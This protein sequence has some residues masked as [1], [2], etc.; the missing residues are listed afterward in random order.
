M[1]FNKKQ[2][3]GCL[4]RTWF[5]GDGGKQ[6]P[7]RIG[8]STDNGQTFQTVAINGNFIGSV[9]DLT[10]WVKQ[11]N[12]FL[13][14]FEAEN[15]AP[16]TPVVIDQIEIVIVTGESVRPVL[17]DLPKALGLLLL[18]GILFYCVLQKNISKTQLIAPV[19]LCFI[20][21]LAAYL[22]WNELLRV[23]GTILDDDA[24][25]YLQYAKK[26]AL[27]SSTGFYS[28]Q[29]GL[30]EP[31]FIFVVKVFFF[32][33]GDSDTHLRFVS[34]TFS[35][36][37]IILTYKMGS[38]WFNELV[39]LSAALILAIHPYLIELSARGLRGELYTVLLLLFLYFG[40]IKTDLTS[41]QKTVLTGFVMGLLFLTRSE[42]FSILPCMVFCYIFTRKSRW[43]LRMAVAAIVIGTLLCLPHFY[44]T[45]KKYGDPFYAANRHARFYANREF[46]GKPG[47]PTQV[48][49]AKEGM[50]IGPKITPFEYLFKLHTPKQIIK[51]RH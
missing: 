26:M 32:L 50:Y 6:Q 38:R 41:T 25:G 20:I 9:F 22:R 2:G 33:F 10:P 35:L 7:N 8:V 13:L 46:A 42:S 31:F 21:A 16:F 18:M 44:N 29:F 5:Y 1:S 11:S 19:F 48:E 15:T 23:S 36:A 37:V 40:Y 28:A 51:S 39:G 43:G 4:L 12:H 34:F 47:F 24:V 3:N 27:I 30:R 17:P 45:Y 14:Q 49:I